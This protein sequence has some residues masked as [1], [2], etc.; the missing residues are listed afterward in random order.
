MSEQQLSCG[1]LLHIELFWQ[2]FER[3]PVWFL[4]QNE[5]KRKYKISRLNLQ[6]AEGK[7]KEHSFKHTHY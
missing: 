5:S 7:I 2:E 3:H 1:K 6:M 4:L